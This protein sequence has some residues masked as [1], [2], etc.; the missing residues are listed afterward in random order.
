MAGLSEG[1]MEDQAAMPGFTLGVVRFRP[2]REGTSAE[3]VDDVDELRRRLAPYREHERLVI[4][5]DRDGG[6]AGSVWVHLTGD[7]AWVTHFVRLGG[8]D[9]Y[10]RDPGYRGPDEMVGFLLSNGQLDEIHR[11]WTVSRAEGLQALEHFVRDGGR[12]PA[13]CWVEEPESLQG[14]A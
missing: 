6:E 3:P 13:L 4:T 9:A 10:C 1:G 14:L 5:L 12:D 2:A 11:N 7:R 8:T